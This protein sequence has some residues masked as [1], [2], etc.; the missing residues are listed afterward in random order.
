MRWLYKLEY[1]YGK[2]SIRNLMT[3]IIGG[4]AIV[5]LMDMM[6]NFSL[7]SYLTFYRPFILQG[8]VWRVLT[9]LFVPESN[10]PL[11]LLISLYCYYLLGNLLEQVWGSFKLNVY[12]LVGIV[13]T[14]IAGFISPAGFTSNS[15]LNS[16]LFLAVAALM[17]ETQFR[18]FFIIP[19]KAKWMG[20]AYFIFMIP[21][22]INAF[23]V[24]ASYGGSYLII[25]AFSLLN[26]FVFF[27]RT[28]WDSARN[29]IRIWK[30]QRNWKNSNRR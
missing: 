29:Q 6:L 27:G 24:S 2:Y 16:S 15:A 20:I 18:L 25:L 17:P 5:Y 1:K 7:S 4:M 19:I 22:V 30:N 28:L 23:S 3:I 26:F 12:Y 9:F 11:M 8:Q 21:D 10:S 13:G 14:I